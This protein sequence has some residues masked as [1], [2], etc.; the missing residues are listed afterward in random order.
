MSDR[1]FA[2]LTGR[3]APDPAPSGGGKPDPANW[4]FAL[5]VFFGAAQIIAG[6]IYFFAFNWRDLSDIAKIALPQAA[7]AIAFLGFALSPKKSAVGAAAGVLAT[8]MIGVSMGVVG[9]VY[10]LG[11]DPWQLFA[12]WAAFALPLAIL[13]RDDAH[14]AVFFLIATTAWFLW[15]DATWAR[16]TQEQAPQAIYAGL[17]VFLLLAREFAGGAPRWLRW[18]FAA[19]ALLAALS[20]ALGEIDDRELFRDGFYASGVLLALVAALFGLYALWKPD[21]PTRALALFAAAVYV[22]FFGVRTIFRMDLSGSGEMTF[23]FA[24]SALWV[25]AVTAGLAAL[26]RKDRS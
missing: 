7:M 17:A 5:F 19:S 13:A 26:L 24:L 25:V 6:A 8:V 23:A 1:V 4:A 22:G 2:P 14:F 11:A 9:Q 16:T 3:A 20:A 10:Q 15:T 18:F 12:I 21:R